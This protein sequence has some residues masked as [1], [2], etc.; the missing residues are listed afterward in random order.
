MRKQNLAPAG[1]LIVVAAA[2]ATAGLVGVPRPAA[3]APD[4]PSL[5]VQLNGN[6][7]RPGEVMELRVSMLT[8]A[9]RA[10]TDAYVVLQTPGQTYFS[11][12]LGGSLVPGVVPIARR[13]A[14]QNASIPI[15]TVTIPQGTP[16]GEYRWLSALTQ[17]GTAN[18]YDGISEV[19]FRVG[20]SPSTRPFL[21]LNF[22]P[23]MFD[24]SPDI[25]AVVSPTQITARLA[26]IAPWTQWIRLFGTGGGLDKAPALAKGFGLK[27]A[28]AAWLSNDPVA[29]N[30]ELTALETLGRA[31]QCDM[32]IVGNETL[33]F[34]VL[35][36][37]Q[38]VSY[39]ARVKAAVPGVSVT[40]ADTSGKLLEPGNASVLAAVDVVLHNTYPYWEGTALAQAPAQLASRHAA[41]VAAVPRKKVIV[42]E[43]GW[44]TCGNTSGAA[45]PSPANAAQY[46]SAVLAWAHA[47]AVDVFYFSGFDEKWKATEKYPQEACFGVWDRLGNIKT[48]MAPVLSGAP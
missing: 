19:R 37:G 47:A 27:V 40:T 48:A 39:I 6:A 31:G 33:Q 21:G 42:S 24:Q 34:N 9:Q 14:A 8:G 25:G 23:F 2:L 22:S 26:T 16:S 43:T 10:V 28:C 36:A 20:G 41:L 1:R 5:S 30:Q 11:L 13:L 35:S 18:I 12:Q 4:P 17:T 44:P 3:A 29:D 46:L 15:W 32:L 45:I 38:L 7:F